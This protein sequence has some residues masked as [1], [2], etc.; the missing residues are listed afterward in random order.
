MEGKNDQYLKYD[1]HC[2]FM[3]HF[4]VIDIETTGGQYNRDKII[5]VAII[6]TDGKKVI[7]DF[8]TLIH[9]ERPIPPNITRITGIND[10]MVSDAPKFYEIAREIVEF[11]TGCIFVAHN[12]RFDYSFIKEEFKQL[13]FSYNRKTLCTVK[14]TKSLVGGLPSYGLD[15]LSKHFS[16]LIHDRHRAY[17][18]ALAT[19]KILWELLEYGEDEFH[20]KK[21]LNR[22]LDETV[23]PKGIHIDD[24]HNT[25][26]SAGVYYLLDSQDEIFYVG[27][28]KNIRKRLFQHF[29]ELSRKALHIYNR[30]HGIRVKET[31]SELMALLLELRE[32][33]ENRPELNRSMKRTK[34]AYAICYRDDWS[35]TRPPFVVTRLGDK[36]DY[37]DQNILRLFGVKRGANAY[38][39]T[40][41]TEDMTC[42]KLFHSR[43]TLFACQCEGN[44]TIFHDDMQKSVVRMRQVISNEFE[45]D[46][47]VKLPGRHPSEEGIVV[48]KDGRFYGY[49]FHPSESTND[50]VLS[51]T[52]RF[53]YAEANSIVRQHLYSPE[54]LELIKIE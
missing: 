54:I 9:P 36:V 8:Q 6:V 39:Q 13:G 18:D 17:G 27:K 41:L 24:I 48:V 25:P 46:L 42:A 20:I 22:G 33:K 3:K 4:A 10:A 21:I 35:D 5:E 34:Y 38:V 29:R 23:L 43:N 1:R 47:V 11:T 53:F 37:H 12:A 32:I 15:Y 40:L 19:C 52:T 45:S 16:V 14:L 7:R 30:V 26:E 51:V 28:A 31:G 50:P 2:H 49:G 44:C